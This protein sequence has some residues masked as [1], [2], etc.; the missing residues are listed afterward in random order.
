MAITLNLQRGFEAES[1]EPTLSAVEKKSRDRIILSTYFLKI[2]HNYAFWALGCFAVYKCLQ[3]LCTV[4]SVLATNKALNYCL[5]WSMAL[6]NE[7]NKKDYFQVVSLGCAIEE[8]NFQELL[9]EHRQHGDLNEKK[10]QSIGCIYF[11]SYSICSIR[12]FP[13]AEMGDNILHVF[14]CKKLSSFVL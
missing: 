1:D 13:T 6:D 14:G 4:D 11:K 8:Q 3:H 5:A 9:V 7:D 2:V 12:P 10:V